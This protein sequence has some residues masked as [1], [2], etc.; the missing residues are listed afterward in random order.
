MSDATYRQWARLDM[1]G[2]VV[3][4]G[5][6]IV[7]REESSELLSEAYDAVTRVMETIVGA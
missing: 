7:F 5:L 3:V 2:M 4:L 1:Y 6:F